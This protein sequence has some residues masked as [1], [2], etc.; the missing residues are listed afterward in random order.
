MTK[1]D[2]LF[3]PQSIAVVGASNR[4]GSVGNSLMKNLVGEYTGMIF[5]INP[6][7][8]SVLGVKAYPSL[9]SV[10][11]A[12]DCVIVA[13]PAATIPQ[14]IKDA[15][16]KKVSGMVIISAGFKE[17]G[18]EGQKLFE[19]AQKLAKKAGIRVIGPN[20][21]GFLRPACN[22]NASFSHR[23]P[24]PG[25]L[26]FISQS[27]A[28]CTA[29]L[30]WSLST[31]VGFSHF[32]S[33]GS[34]MDVGFPDLI[35]HFGND[36][37]TSAILI[38]MESIDDPG[39][40]IR[41]A[42]Q[43]TAHK[44]I[45]VVKVGKSSQG[46]KAAKS[47]TGSLAGNDA[48]FDAAFE[49]AG[50]TRVDNCSALYDC[51]QLLS[52]PLP[53]GDRLAVVTNAGGPGVITTDT[54][55]EA[56]GRIAQLSEKTITALDK[57]LP[58]TWSHNNPV[59]VL[60]DAG[61]RRYHDALS[62][63]KKDPQVDGIITI[64][65]PQSMTD[66][67]AVA[68]SLDQLKVNKPLMAVWM[69]EG[70]VEGGR[71][72]LRDSHLPV[73]RYP[74]QAVNGFM[75][76]VRHNEHQKRLKHIPDKYPRFTVNK[77]ANTKLLKALGERT[78]LTE[79]EAKEFVRQY[80]IPVAQYRI[81]ESLKDA[82]AIGE[83]LGYPLMLKILS[84]DII[85]K[86]D[87]NGVRK[88][89]SKAELK[90]TFDSI[91]KTARKHHPKAD[92]HGILLEEMVETGHELLIGAKYDEMFG[93]TIM[94]GMGGTAVEL[95]RDTNLALVPL[96]RQGAHQL[97]EKTKIYSLLRGYRGQKG[98]DLKALEEVLC[99]V[100]QMLEDFP[101]IHELDIN[102]FSM[103]ARGGVA[104]DVKILLRKRF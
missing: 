59:D 62:I 30:D 41:I 74:Q 72:V 45:I 77:A 42:R 20:C 65:T 15:A 14:I 57:V 12:I 31:N 9:S 81:A 24:K 97:M 36:P 79:F 29:I 49:R 96:N 60:G 92:I 38:Y 48:A 78:A 71:T 35:E 16:K 22:L 76:L 8:K 6:K 87:V 104:L 39:R 37:D 25:H 27:G 93:H 80:K 28:L 34:M 90:T 61:E 56:G 51:A 3:N 13:T 83:N 43:V 94:F 91:I 21:L 54:I 100:S 70:D 58:P 86:T 4:P 11:D 46:A 64:L 1:L 75:T 55:I 44:P 68:Q 33:V 17:A 66:S 63:V 18:P 32:V 5:P 99:R 98:V 73:Y 50:I 89:S 2:V 84:P 88:V 26:A 103:G 19:E 102:P 82:V 95:Y 40:F 53:K 52:Q 23:M 47:H 7:R 10:P 67:V 69:G 85:H 101:Q